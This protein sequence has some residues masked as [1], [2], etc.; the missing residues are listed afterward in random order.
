[1]KATPA[2]ERTAKSLERTGETVATTVVSVRRRMDIAMLRWQARMD[3][4]AW[5]RSL[6]W[7]TA[8]VL[9]TFLSLLALARSQDLGIGYQLGHYLQAAD[10][11]D[12]GFEPVVSDLGYN[13][14]ADQGAW[15]F[16]PIA[17]ALRVL[18]VAGTLLVLQ[19]VALALGV[20]P[21]WWIVRAPS[22]LRI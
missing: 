7:F 14:F 6:P 2:L 3:S 8:V 20:V 1:M 16:W 13:L 5:D 15:I 9:A 19:S 21:F 10:L 22:N 4:R 18:P 17:W 12:R 11:M